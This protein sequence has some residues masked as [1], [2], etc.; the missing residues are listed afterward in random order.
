[1]VPGRHGGEQGARGGAGEPDQRRRIRAHA[2]EAWVG[3]MA[4]AADEGDDLAE[5]A[6][7]GLED[8]VQLLR[9]QSGFRHPR[10]LPQAFLLHSDPSDKL[11]GLD[12]L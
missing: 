1:M 7:D 3:R 5:L 8:P 2:D 4:A 9:L 11:F 12:Y 10:S 6:A